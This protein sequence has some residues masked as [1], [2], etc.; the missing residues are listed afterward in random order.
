LNLLITAC[1]NNNIIQSD[2]QQGGISITTDQQ[3]YYWTDGIGIK[4]LFVSGKLQNNSNKSYLSNVFDIFGSSDVIWFAR[5][6]DGKIEKYDTVDTTWSERGALLDI[7]IEGTST[8]EIKP[9]KIYS[10]TAPLHTDTVSYQKEIGKYRLRI[11]YYDTFDEAKTSPF[12]IY[13]N[14]FEIH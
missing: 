10:I 7:L 6:S 11:D 5:G 4:I 3:I 9:L 8:R 1:K 13:S 14:V 12:N 2:L